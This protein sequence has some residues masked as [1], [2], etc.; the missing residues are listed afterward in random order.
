MTQIYIYIERERSTD[1]GGVTSLT[2]NEES[3]SNV[4]ISGTIIKFKVSNFRFHSSD[5]KF[6]MFS[7]TVQVLSLKFKD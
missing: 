3:K 2:P 4:R 6:Q 5:F 1:E 7:L